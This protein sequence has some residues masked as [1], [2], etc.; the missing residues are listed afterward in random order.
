MQEQRHHPQLKALVFAGTWRFN[1]QEQL[2]LE[3]EE[4][5]QPAANVSFALH[6]NYTLKQ[7][8]SGLYRSSYTGVLH[9]TDNS[10]VQDQPDGWHQPTKLILISSIP[11]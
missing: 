8:L 9:S 7:G 4:A 5:I 2:I 11:D 3:F 6:F 1:D 10:E